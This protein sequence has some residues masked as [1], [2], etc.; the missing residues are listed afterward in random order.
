MTFKTDFLWGGATAANQL[1]GA[2]DIDGKGLSVADAMP[3]GKERLAI[4]AS[5]EFDWTIDIE[6]FT[7]PNHDGIDHYHHFKE[8]IALFAEMGFKAYRFSVA[9]SRI[10][11]MGDETTPNEKVCFFMIS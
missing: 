10:F 7:Y 8:D 3:G 5:P 4:L 11:P 2:Y 1:E 6:H 9:W